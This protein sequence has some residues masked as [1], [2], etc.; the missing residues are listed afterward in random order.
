M[1]AGCRQEI[2]PGEFEPTWPRAPF[3]L[4]VIFVTHFNIVYYAIV[5]LP[6]KASVI[7]IPTQGST[8]PRTPKMPALSHQFRGFDTRPD[9]VPAAE[10]EESVAKTERV[11]QCLQ[12][13]VCGPEIHEASREGIEEQAALRRPEQDFVGRTIILIV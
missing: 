4:E 12:A 5:R 8:F 6:A 9:R 3:C 7:A 13:P 11:A 1:Q 2:G 10:Q